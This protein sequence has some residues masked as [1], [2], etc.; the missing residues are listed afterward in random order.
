MHFRIALLLLAVFPGACFAK[1]SVDFC[2]SL[3]VSSKLTWQYNEGGDFIVCIAVRPGDKKELF[4]VYLGNHPNFEHEASL[5]ATNG[6]VGGHKVVWY[7]RAKSDERDFLLASLT[8]IP[9]GRPELPLKAHI[10]VMP[11]L[12]RDLKQ[13]FQTISNMQFKS[14]WY[15]VGP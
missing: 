6:V 10:W 9:G 12:K 15:R 14:Q 4:G 13:T 11:Q 5:V 8:E 2:P 1:R 3:P 7:M